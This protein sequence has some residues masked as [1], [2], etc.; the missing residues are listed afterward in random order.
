MVDLARPSRDVCHVW[1]NRNRQKTL[2]LSAL[3]RPPSSPSHSSSSPDPDPD[4][5]AFAAPPSND[6]PFHCAGTSRHPAPAMPFSRYLQSNERDGQNIHEDD[7]DHHCFSSVVHFQLPN[8]IF[9]APAVP[10]GGG[11]EALPAGLYPSS[12]SLSWFS[13]SDGY[14]S[15]LS[16]PDSLLSLSLQLTAFSSPQLALQSLSPISPK[17]VHLLLAPLRLLRPL[18]RLKPTSH[19]SWSVSR[20]PRISPKSSF[21]SPTSSLYPIRS[22]S[23]HLLLLG[24]RPHFPPRPRS[25]KTLPQDLPRPSRPLMLLC[26]H[27]HAPLRFSHRC[28]FFPPL[29]LS[30]FISFSSLRLPFLPQAHRLRRA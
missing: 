9:S 11:A 15:P 24:L 19:L 5:D 27:R 22:R 26:R 20:S 8:L 2:L 7:P 3:L 4:P 10:P 16:V 14:S 1:Q 17:P 23:S 29:P 13:A 28:V 12:S 25:I 18:P 30:Y 21:P 6:H